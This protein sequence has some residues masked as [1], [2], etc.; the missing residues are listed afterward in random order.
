LDGSA[1]PFYQGLAGAG[2]VEQAAPQSVYQL[3]APVWVGAGDTCLLALPHH[4][5]LLEYALHYDHP[6]IG[7]QQCSFAVWRDSF[8]EEL[9]PAATFA[10]WEEVQVL[11]AKGLAKG[12]SLDNALVAHQDHWSRPLRL[13][14][15]PARH[16]CMDLLGD[17]S[18]FGCPL[19]ARVIAVRA[20]HR[21]HVELVRKL[22]KETVHVNR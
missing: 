12:G 16:K 18:L 5:P 4:E 11:L 22:R 14:K 8:A 17:L 9:A 13:D 19:Q 15:E 21:W 10:L 3:K 6:M 20:G 2:L 1:L 7:C